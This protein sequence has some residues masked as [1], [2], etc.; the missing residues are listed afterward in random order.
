MPSHELAASAAVDPTL[1]VYRATV[2]G[3]PSISVPGS[4][5][6][7]RQVIRDEEGDPI[8]LDEI[9]DYPPESLSYP[10]TLWEPTAFR[11]E[12]LE[13]GKTPLEIPATTIRQQYPR[14]GG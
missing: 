9:G 3:L 11:G 5:D 14:W 12:V 1:G 8:E 4:N 6:D 7:G 13:V 2:H 10:F